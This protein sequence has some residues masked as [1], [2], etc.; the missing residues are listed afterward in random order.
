MARRLAALGENRRVPNPTNLL[1]RHY[2]FGLRNILSVLRTAGQTKRASMA[3]SLGVAGAAAAQSMPCVSMSPPPP[4]SEP[5]L[6]YQTLRDMNLSKLIAQVG[7]S[8]RW[9]VWAEV[10]W[11]AVGLCG[12]GWAGQPVG[13]GWVGLGWPVFVH[14]P[15]SA[16]I[17]Q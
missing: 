11:S 3:S 15:F 8:A 17:S 12:L 6:M 7:R 14:G 10:G 2:D 1:Q 4:V 5:A 16:W 9:V 13:L